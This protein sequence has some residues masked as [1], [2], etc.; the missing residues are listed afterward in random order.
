[1][2]GSVAERPM[3]YAL[4]EGVDRRSFQV[5]VHAGL[6]GVNEAQWA[7][8]FGKHPDRY[9]L[10]NL[11]VGCGMEGIEFSTIQVRCDDD[12]VMVAPVFRARFDIASMVEGPAA[13]YV[14]GAARVFPSLFKP[15]LMGIGLVECEWGSVGIKRSDDAAM[16]ARAWELVLAEFTRLARHSR[17]RLL[18]L[19]DMDSA[20]LGFAP[21]S[22][23]RQF[24]SVDTEPCAQVMLGYPTV[25]AYLATLSSST[26]QRLRRR[27]RKSKA[28]RIEQRTDAGEQLDRMY[29]LYLSTVERSPMKLGIQRREYFEEFCGRVNG[30]YYVLYFLGDR[31]LAF[32]ALVEQT[33]MI[34]DKYFCMEVPAGR[35]HNLY[36]VSW[37]ENIRY[38]VERG[39]SVYHAGPGAE[40]T[41]KH[42]GC[43]FICNE[44]LFRHTNPLI[45]K[46]FAF[47][48]GTI[49]RQSEA[50]SL[51]RTSED[52]EP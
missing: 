21:A 29:E 43:R 31:L 19:L 41:K 16:I 10:I 52:G 24:V 26:R 17:T 7:E 13:R 25:D 42:L 2:S 11:T 50:K 23:R 40:D 48:A 47:L 1:M 38:A 34:V 14:R 4:R 44:T 9:D 39:K 33:D 18:T 3:E 28:I 46:A 12:L 35:D 30:G 5:S 8:L 22:V 15:W 6:G 27:V 51:S 37:M 45:H 49:A 32:N 36:F 20:S